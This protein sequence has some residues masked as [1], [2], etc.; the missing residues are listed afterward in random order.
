L[1]ENGNASI[2]PQ[3]VDNGSSDNC[4]IAEQNIDVSNFSCAEIGQNAVV[5][6]V[7]DASGNT[8]AGTAI[9][10]VEDNIA[11]VLTC[12]D[13]MVLSAC[14]TTASFV[15]QATDNCN[16]NPVVLQTTG[17]PS[18]ASFPAGTTVQTFTTNDGHGNQSTCS[19]TIQVPAALEVD[20]DVENITCFGEMDGSIAANVA[21]G[22]QGYTYA[23]SNGAVTPSINGLGAGD[24]TVSVTDLA[25]CQSVQNTSISSPFII[26]STAVDIKPEATGQANGSIDAA[27]QGGTLPYTF[28]WT[29]ASG[30]I[31]STEEDVAGL[32]AG[33]YNLAV[34]DGNGCISL[35]AFTV[36]SVSAVIHRQ[37]EKSISLFPNPTTGGLTI[38]FDEI[39]AFEANISVF[40][41]TG[42]LAAK[43]DQADISAG[44]YYLDLSRHADGVYLVRIMIDNQIVTKRLVVQH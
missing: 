30:N 43:H 11:P 27:V 14:E 10:T 33:T 17:L 44:L 41:M 24:Y 5:L 31:I 15:L 35:H 9:V 20:L 32:V 19:F 40:D 4:G 38:A 1:D 8:A 6:F 23:W 16:T 13:N 3:M 12:P 37:L 26:V 42:K 22:T 28:E 34:T 25:G 39:E 29:D 7:K 18:G 21:G 2:T 36:P